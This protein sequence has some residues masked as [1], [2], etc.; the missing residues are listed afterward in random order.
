[1]LTFEI[2]LPVLNEA[3]TIE[4]QMTFLL[5]QIQPGGSP[6]ASTEPVCNSR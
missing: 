4:E 1:M 5:N 2:C 6:S 3:Q